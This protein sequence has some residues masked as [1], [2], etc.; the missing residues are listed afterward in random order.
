MSVSPEGLRIC[1]STVIDLHEAKTLQELAPALF[2]FIAEVLPQ[3]MLFLMLRPLE[4]NLQSFHSRP[5]FQ[6]LVD[7]YMSHGYRDDIWLQR[8]PQTPKIPVVRHSLY[9]PKAIFRRSRFYQRVMQGLGCEYGASLVA[10]R[11]NIWLGNLTILRT[12]QQ[13]DFR[14][15][16]LS[17]LATC[18]LHF[19][20]A[21]KR[22]AI[23]QEEKLASKS[24][25]AIIWKLPT[26]ALVLDWNLK[27]LHWNAS[28]QELVA[29]WK[30]S[31]GRRAVKPSRHFSIP[32]EIVSAIERERP[33]L[34][35][36]RPNRPKGPN[37]IPVSEIRHPQLED[38]TANVSFLP[39]K[40]L[41]ISKG[42]F[43][44]LF[45]W[46]QVTH[47]DRDS[48]DRLANLTR[49][50]R[51]VVLMAASGKNSRQICK[52]LGTSSVTVRKQLHNAYKKLGINSRFE[53][54]AIFARNP[55]TSNSQVRGSLIKANMS[56][57][58]PA[59]R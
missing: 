23:F 51:D 53:L 28:S 7:E 49:R 16:E 31:H 9:T 35:E 15:D 40:S 29:I 14:D 19:E 44:I 6:E 13:G 37:I 11:Q 4:H 8:S 24:L 54:M 39:C 45:H 47:D 12:K 38:L 46:N 56:K 27:L 1:N 17:L 59:R 41:A 55:L 52:E 5:E 36:I 26:S 30:G 22:I 57:N 25:A 21:I 48:Y 32:C 18:H 50:E 20:S 33:R 43:V 34:N 2:K 58:R 10:W 42:T 3:N